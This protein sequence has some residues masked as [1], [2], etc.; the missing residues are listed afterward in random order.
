MSLTIFCIFCLDDTDAESVF[1]VSNRTVG[2]F[3]LPAVNPVIVFFFGF[4]GQSL[5]VVL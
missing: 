4:R 2:V 5:W 1:S 3:T